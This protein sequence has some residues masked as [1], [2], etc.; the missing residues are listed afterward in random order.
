MRNFGPQFFFFLLLVA[1]AITLACGSSSPSTRQLQTVTIS[2][3]SADGQA[4]FS[5]TGDYTKPPSPVSPLTV[6][7]GACYQNVPTTEVTVS[8]A[9]FA[10]CAAGAST[11]TYTVW[12]YG[13]NA[14]GAVCNAI[15]AC[16][17]GCGRVTGTAQLTCP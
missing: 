14:Q 4:Q 15:T 16:G 3:A 5:A 6:T 17:G 8:S 9:G 1:A 13:S 11:G 7:W 2:P 12:A 10:Q